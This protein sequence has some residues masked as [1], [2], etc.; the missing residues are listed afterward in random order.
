MSGHGRNSSTS[1][2]NTITAGSSTTDESLGFR[3]ATFEL[4]R[5]FSTDS[6]TLFCT[7]KERLS[8]R[9]LAVR[10]TEQSTHSE[11]RHHHDLRSFPFVQDI[12]SVPLTPVRLK[13]QRSGERH[14]SLK[15]ANGRSRTTGLSFAEICALA[16]S[17]GLKHD[18]RSEYPFRD[19]IHNPALKSLRSSD[20]TRLK[21]SASAR[22]PKRR[23][24]PA[25]PNA[26]W[27]IEDMRGESPF[28]DGALPAQ[29]QLRPKTSK[30]SLSSLFSKPKV[31]RQ[32]GY[33]EAGLAAPPPPPAKDARVLKAEH[34]DSLLTPPEILRSGSA[35]SF[36]SSA[37][38]TPSDRHKDLPRPPLPTIDT[39]A[40]QWEPIPL[41]QAYAQSVKYGVLEVSPIS[42]ESVLQKSKASNL[43]TPGAEMT[44]R[45]SSESRNST[46]TKRTTRSFVKQSAGPTPAHTQLPKK[47]FVLT[48][49]GFLLRYTETGPSGRLPEKALQLCTDSAALVC[50]VVPGRG[51]V[52][53]ISHAVDHQGRLVPASQSFFGRLGRASAAKRRISSLLLVMSGP[54]EMESWMMAVKEEIDKLGGPLASA[55]VLAGR[56]GGEVNSRDRVEEGL[57]SN[58]SGVQNTP[59][60]AMTTSSRTSVM[61]PQKPQSGTEPPLPLP[62]SHSDHSEHSD[63]PPAPI[64]KDT[65]RKSS[66]K[67]VIAHH[68]NDPEELAARVTVDNANSR[69][70]SGN[71]RSSSDTAS[72]ASTAATSFDL[73]NGSVRN[74][75]LSYST[76]ATSRTNSMT[77]SS[78]T[79]SVLHEKIGSDAAP[80]K[81][82]NRVSSYGSITKRRSA[83]PM[84]VTQEV[85]TQQEQPQ[86]YNKRKSALLVGVAVTRSP[87]VSGKQQSPNIVPDDQSKHDSKMTPPN[88]IA[89]DS[90]RPVS[91]VGDLPSAPAWSA[92]RSPNKRTSLGQSQPSTQPT[93]HKSASQPAIR[94]NQQPAPR[95][96]RMS[97]QPFGLKIN[98]PNSSETPARFNRTSILVSS[99]ES[100]VPGRQKPTSTPSPAPSPQ[101]TPNASATAA[102]AAKPSPSPSVPHTRTTSSA[103][104]SL[105][106]SSASTALPQASHANNHP[107]ES[108]A[109]RRP[110]SMQVRSS[111]APFLTSASLYSANPNNSSARSQAQDGVGSENRAA[112]VAPLPVRSLKSSRSEVFGFGVGEGA[113]L[114]A[115]SRDSGGS[116]VGSDSSGGLS[117]DGLTPGSGS[118]LDFVATSNSVSSNTVGRRLRSPTSLPKLDFGLPVVGLGPPVAPPPRRALPRVPGTG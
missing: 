86:D 29:H 19:S 113:G 33:A 68:T 87:P 47:I 98:P 81:A 76:A 70:K 31:E 88:S 110:S 101:R 58:T 65:V 84:P 54:E 36:R 27:H 114:G 23:D 64:R 13:N 5:S 52:L 106:P 51:H 89:E 74:K 99:S 41:F 111:Y 57:V 108:R 48:T 39:S 4:R 44:H 20:H 1:S 32:K 83:M 15:A 22:L 3:R 79:G 45:E 59:Y 94:L 92:T 116:K 109:L 107:S 60:P 66:P 40:S 56:D 50:E 104:L 72:V 82:G 103:R 112:S 10:E 77:T 46:E 9:S 102:A 6:E 11:S 91:F 42:A 14:K 21:R 85:Q 37:T 8:S 73:Q 61:M 90:E 67:A 93:V 16:R 18:P 71:V 25:K 2:A 69:S 17:D 117:S 7:P 95:A 35:M 24:W 43:R 55:D 38:R 28:K 49:S 12:K 100:P 96:R 75:R 63:T 30:F 97:S 105:F 62:R 78:P 80:V 115:G 34:L 118:D 26:A 53:Q